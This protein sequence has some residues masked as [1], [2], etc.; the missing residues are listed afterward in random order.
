MH[1]TTDIRIKLRLGRPVAEYRT[2]TAGQ[3]TRWLAMDVREAEAHLAAQAKASVAAKVKEWHLTARQGFAPDMVRLPYLV[4]I[5]EGA[6]IVIGVNHLRQGL[7]KGHK[8]T[9]CQGATVEV[10]E[11]L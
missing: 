10:L 4:R 2:T 3:P 11:A 6:R 8:F 9:N 7:A 1:T 5:T